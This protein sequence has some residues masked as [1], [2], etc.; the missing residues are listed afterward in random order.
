MNNL[1]EKS[2]EVAE[3]SILKDRVGRLADRRVAAS[4]GMRNLEGDC[5]EALLANL[6][7]EVDETILPRRLTVAIAGGGTIEVVVSNRR[8]IGLTNVEASQCTD[9]KGVLDH[10]RSAIGQSTTAESRSERT[11]NTFSCA[12]TGVSARALLALLSVVER[13]VPDP[14]PIPSFF[15]ELQSQMLAWVTLSRT[16]R[17]HKKAG[18]VLWQD[19]LVKLANSQLADLEAQRRQSRTSQGQSS[20]V[21]LNFG[22]EDGFILLYARSSTSGFLAMLPMACLAEIES[23][24]KARP[25]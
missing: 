14:N 9:P 23:A 24:W 15:A 22:D 17:I 12:H 1:A 19:R 10:L 3:C 7:R 5:A 8:L 20:C 6:L 11:E 16:G 25:G 21:L 4:G 18:E 2:P 13:D